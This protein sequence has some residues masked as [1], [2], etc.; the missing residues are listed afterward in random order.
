MQ[1]LLLRR[2]HVTSTSTLHHIL[3]AKH[4][5]VTR[6]LCHTTLKPHYKFKQRGSPSKMEPP[7][8]LLERS[9]DGRWFVKLTDRRPKSRAKL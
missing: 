1:L 6:A 4:C 5:P 3:H 9:R 7:G 2:K 8:V